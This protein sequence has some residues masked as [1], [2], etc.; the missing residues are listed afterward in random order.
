MPEISG[1]IEAAL[2]VEDMQRSVEFY[3]RVCGCP[4]PECAKSRPRS[5]DSAYQPQVPYRLFGIEEPRPEA[6]T[7]V[8]TRCGLG[9]DPHEGRGDRLR[10]ARAGRAGCAAGDAKDA[11]DE[12][13]C[14]E[15]VNSR[16]RGAV[17]SRKR[18]GHDDVL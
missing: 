17:V 2:Y 15:T 3:E 4:T 6:D 11:R 16:P 9:R 8:G 10:A 7:G 1:I 18:A 14:Q 13:E 12:R 5:D